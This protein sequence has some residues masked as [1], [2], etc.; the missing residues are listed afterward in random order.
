[1][2]ITLNGKDED[3]VRAFREKGLKDI[4]PYIVIPTL[5]VGDYV[6]IHIEDMVLTRVGVYHVLNSLVSISYI[7]KKDK[8]SRASMRRPFGVNPWFANCSVLG[9]VCTLHSLKISVES[10]SNAKLH[11]RFLFL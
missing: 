2:D 7:R 9:I 3:I 1:M 6:M 5:R 10:I 8:K 4:C 11:F